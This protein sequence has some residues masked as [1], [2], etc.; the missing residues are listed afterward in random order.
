MNRI[1]KY[2]LDVIDRQTVALPIWSSILSVIEQDNR[3]VVYALVDDA[4]TETRDK[5]FRIVGTGH[6]FPDH[7]ECTYLATVST[8]GG[9]LVWHVFIE[10]TLRCL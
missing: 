5:V 3:V 8:F 2:E 4:I 9:S 6:P 1:L 7:E 10:N